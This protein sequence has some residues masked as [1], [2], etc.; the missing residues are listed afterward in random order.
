MSFNVDNIDREFLKK[1]MIQIALASSKIEEKKAA[2]A[3]IPKELPFIRKHIGPIRYR[4]PFPPISLPVQKIKPVEKLDLDLGKLNVLV[5]DLS[6]S[7]IECSGAD[8]NIRIKKDNVSTETEIILT[9][10]EINDII[11]KF[12]EKSNLPAENSLEATISGVKIKAIISPFLGS[13][14][15]LIRE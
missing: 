3:K 2:E 15:I 1:F 13:R 6:V 4:R 5:Q 10:D 7:Y 14:F 11:K 12:A 8:H 9:E